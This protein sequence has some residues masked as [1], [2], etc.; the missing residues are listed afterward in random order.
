M[1]SGGG[2]KAPDVRSKGPSTR[3]IS[4]TGLAETSA[5]FREMGPHLQE[6]VAAKVPEVAAYVYKVGT[7]AVVTPAEKKVVRGGGIKLDGSKI[8]MGNGSNDAG[9][10][11]FGTE[12]GGRRRRHTMQFRPH[13]G[14][15]GYFFWPTVRHHSD[16][17]KKMWDD[18][19]LEL[20]G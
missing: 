6:L 13:K 3:T 18:L 1:A 7:G 17:I 11:T 12:F 16:D 5:E 19:V 4:A 20:I 2:K 15:D 9:V 14:R 10:M 8:I